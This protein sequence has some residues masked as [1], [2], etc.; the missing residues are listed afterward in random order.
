M[1]PSSRNLI[2]GDDKDENHEDDDGATSML[3]GFNAG[4]IKG[5]GGEF[6]II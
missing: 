2:L 4:S 1:Q 3:N 5:T 6:P